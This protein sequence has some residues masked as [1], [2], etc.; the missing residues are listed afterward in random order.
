MA[1][2][3]VLQCP[4]QYATL[5]DFGDWTRR[6]RPIC[7]G[8]AT[9]YLGEGALEVKVV[10]PQVFSSIIALHC[11]SISMHHFMLIHVVATNVI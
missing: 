8:M 6:R 11:I 2:D 1:I 3:I 9:L 4:T 5:W 7:F 10:T